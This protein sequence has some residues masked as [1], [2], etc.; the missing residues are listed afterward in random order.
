MI[1]LWFFFSL[2]LIVYAAC[3]RLFVHRTCNFRDDER[4]AG[5]TQGRSKT[6]KPWWCIILFKAAGLLL[7][8][9]AQGLSRV[10]MNLLTTRVKPRRVL[11]TV[12]VKKRR[13]RRGVLGNAW[14]WPPLI[15]AVTCISKH[16]R[17]GSVLHFSVVS[18]SHLHTN[19][20]LYS[21]MTVKITQLPFYIT[22]LGGMLSR[23]VTECFPVSAPVLLNYKRDEL[24]LWLCCCL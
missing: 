18:R 12:W 16:R 11:F 4:T 21:P 1:F 2:I 3:T 8:C 6:T 23:S 17:S 20:V 7:Y 15:P 9:L 19:D 24:S 13:R 22:P 14:R 5:Q 10:Q